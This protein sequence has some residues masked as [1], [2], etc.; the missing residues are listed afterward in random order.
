MAT[1]PIRRR[2]GR[3][4]RERI[5]AAAVE[6]FTRQ[7][8]NA[9]GIEQLA[10]TAQVSKRTLYVHF[11]T[12]DGLVDAYLAHVE[13]QL[14]SAEPAAD[15]PGLSAR[16]RLLNIFN[17]RSPGARDPLRGCA[18]LNA[19]VEVP[20]PDHPV[21]RRAAQYKRRFAER[22]TDLAREAGARNPETLGEQL[23]LVYDGAASRSTALNTPTGRYARDIAEQ[24]LA[25][26]ING[27]PA[28]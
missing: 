1:S 3:G 14:A 17:E 7:G 27:E 11:P 19:A 5:L 21:H 9:T 2:R 6:L 22:L 23:A 24:L 10:S 18:F 15:S 4:A 20:D 12:K 16:E 28:R 8:I 25:A 26:A 13:E